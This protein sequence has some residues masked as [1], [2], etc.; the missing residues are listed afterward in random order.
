MP[1]FGTFGIVTFN[2]DCAIEQIFPGIKD[3]ESKWGLSR[4]PGGFIFMYFYHT[5]LKY[6]IVTSVFS[7]VPN[8]LHNF[9]SQLG[10]DLR[11]WL[12]HDLIIRTECTF[13]LT[14]PFQG[15]KQ[16]LLS[17]FELI[18]NQFVFSFQCLSLSKW[19]PNVPFAGLLKC[20]GKSV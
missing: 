11:S 12:K 5:I 6:T 1:P 17:P 9:K 10:W 19:L 3:F 4:T 7:C 20:M 16:W 8:V 15:L 14:F 18:W 13:R 2:S